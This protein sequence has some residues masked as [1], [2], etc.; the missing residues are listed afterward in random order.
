MTTYGSG[1]AALGGA[2]AYPSSKSYSGPEQ[3]LAAWNFWQ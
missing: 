3:Y 2:Y 1:E